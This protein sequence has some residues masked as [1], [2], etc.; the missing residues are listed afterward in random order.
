MVKFEVRMNKLPSWDRVITDLADIGCT[1]AVGSVY[2][3]ARFRNM[4]TVRG[5]R[6]RLQQTIDARDRE[7]DPARGGSW[8]KENFWNWLPPRRFAPPLLFQEGSRNLK[9]DLYLRID[10]FRAL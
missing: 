6:P 7:A 2:D 1:T 8:M 9:L 10:T 3:R 5:H 4:A